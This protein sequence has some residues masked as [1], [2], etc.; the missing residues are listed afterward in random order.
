MEGYH[1]YA[2]VGGLVKRFIAYFFNQ[3]IKKLRMFSYLNLASSWAIQAIH[4][5]N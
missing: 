4:H 2:K 5:A 1:G 3:N